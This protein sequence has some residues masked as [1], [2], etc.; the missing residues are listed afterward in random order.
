MQL[1]FL[2][3][4]NIPYMCHKICYCSFSWKIFGSKH[5]FYSSGSMGARRPLQL[6]PCW[7]APCPSPALV[8]WHHDC[9][10]GRPRAGCA[11]G[12]TGCCVLS[13]SGR[14]LTCQ[15]LQPYPREHIDLQVPLC[16]CACPFPFSEILSVSWWTEHSDQIDCS[17]VCY[18][19]LAA[20]SYE[21]W[22]QDVK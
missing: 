16:L 3:I 5:A 15:R 9:S 4:F 20:K 13:L 17:S 12:F 22:K 10:C 11:H 7:L 18:Q 8:A 14:L 2:F 19:V 21:T 1:V 6:G